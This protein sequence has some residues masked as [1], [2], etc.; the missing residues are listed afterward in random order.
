MMSPENYPYL[1]STGTL[2]VAH[3]VYGLHLCS[4]VIGILTGA[5]VVSAFIFS[6]PSIVAV[7]LN[8]IFRSDAHGTFVESHFAWQ[9][10][11][12]WLA[13][14]FLILTLLFGTI[15]AFIGI[16][17]IIYFVGFFVLGIWVAYRMIYGWLKLQQS[18]A[19]SL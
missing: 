17:I 1:P 15:L 9:I 14:L 8:Y 5:S 2:T 12:F 4:I 13:F 7:V 18:Q 6:W 19:L 3:M 11:T 10:R 16:G